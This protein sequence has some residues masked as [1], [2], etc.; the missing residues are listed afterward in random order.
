MRYTQRNLANEI[1]SSLCSQ[2]VLYTYEYEVGV[3]MMNFVLQRQLLSSASSSRT[4]TFHLDRRAHLSGSPWGCWP[5]GHLSRWPAGTWP[6]DSC[7]RSVPQ[8]E[9]TRL[10]VGGE[11]VCRWPLAGVAGSSRFW[12]LGGGSIGSDWN[13]LGYRFRLDSNIS[14]SYFDFCAKFGVSVRETRVS[15]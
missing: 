15:L 2:R 7:R 11:D 9:D 1:I 12:I 4:A 8:L 3:I 10:R 14:L 6:P 5:P 13:I